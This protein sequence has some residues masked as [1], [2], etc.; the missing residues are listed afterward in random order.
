M[1]SELATVELGRR[2]TAPICVG[3]P[4][5]NDAVWEG[6]VRVFDLEGNAKVTGACAWS[7]P[8]GS[9][10]RR[11]YAVPHLG[12]ICLPLDAV[13]TVIVAERRKNRQ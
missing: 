2:L 5:T 8:L 13:S 12:G 9:D 1:C 6:V 7:S 10:K 4:M 3:L 11:F